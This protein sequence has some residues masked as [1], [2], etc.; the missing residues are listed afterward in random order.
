MEP[1]I[2][3]W[4]VYLL[5][6][7]EEMKGCAIFATVICGIGMIPWLVV[8]CSISNIPSA[9]RDSRDEHALKTASRFNFVL[10]VFIICL[11]LVITLPSRNTIIAMIVA[12]NITPHNIERVVKTGRDFKD[13][14]KTDLIDIL[15]SIDKKEKGQGK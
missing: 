8:K 11:F 14:I 13:E 6:V 7:I 9:D 10:P 4:L 5:G 3:P 1:I 15:Q 2:S 12:K